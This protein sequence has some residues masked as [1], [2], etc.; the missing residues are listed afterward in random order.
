M[1]SA[2]AVTGSGMWEGPATVC[3]AFPLGDGRGWR[4]SGRGDGAPIAARRGVAS[5]QKQMRG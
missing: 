5:S 1:G 4:V 2:P 3:E